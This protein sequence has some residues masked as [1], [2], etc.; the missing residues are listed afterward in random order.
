MANG[1]PAE[2]Y[3]NSG[4]RGSF[5][6]GGAPLVLHPDFATRVWEAAGCARLVV[7]GF[8]ID[9]LRDLLRVRARLLADQ[10]SVGAKDEA[11]QCP[12]IGRL[13]DPTSGP[14]PPLG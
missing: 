8:E 12:A 10:V 2:S 11:K 3:L 13:T 6:D 7:I 5:E 14:L 1:L 4:D 9:V